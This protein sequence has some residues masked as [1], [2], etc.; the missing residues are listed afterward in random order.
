MINDKVFLPPLHQPFA[1]RSDGAAPGV[2]ISA[3][4]TAA[5]NPAD[6]PK[7]TLH[8]AGTLGAVLP[9]AYSHQFSTY[10]HRGDEAHG[11]TAPE[12]CWDGGDGTAVPC[13][14]TR[15]GTQDEPVDLM[16]S[17]AAETVRIAQPP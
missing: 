14:G 10:A 12:R 8:N 6:V 2:G 16:Y 13:D 3:P 5:G 7:E 11:S 1:C 4:R 9:C 17:T 15:E